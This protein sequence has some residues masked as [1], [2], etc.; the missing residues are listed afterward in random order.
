MTAVAEQYIDICDVPG[1]QIDLNVCRWEP[2]LAPAS[3]HLLTL[4]AVVTGRGE[5]VGYS[6]VEKGEPGGWLR[7][8][9]IDAPALEKIV[10]RCERSHPG[11]K[12]NGGEAVGV[13][14]RLRVHFN[15]AQARRRREP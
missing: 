1:A 3:M 10:R 5:S 7:L 15:T 11:W 12:L 14:D 6:Y 8:R 4:L 2:D 9:E 13:H